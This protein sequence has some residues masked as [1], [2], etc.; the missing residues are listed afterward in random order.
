MGRP[1]LQ[2]GAIHREVL[3]TE[4][5]LDLWSTHQF[6]QVAANDIVIEES[7][8]V[9]GECGGMPDRIIR[10]QACQMSIR[11]MGCVNLVDR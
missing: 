4:Q 7:L 6:L 5:G 10:A 1:G 11:L 9:F 2:K 3:V 8:A